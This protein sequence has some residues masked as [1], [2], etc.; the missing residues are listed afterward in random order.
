MSETETITFI[1]LPTVLKRV[2]LSRSTVYR[3]IQKSEFPQPIKQ[4]HLSLWVD[5][6]VTDWQKAQIRRSAG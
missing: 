1:R 2:G 5:S 3:M 4:G 6:Q